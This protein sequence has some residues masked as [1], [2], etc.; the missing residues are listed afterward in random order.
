MEHERSIIDI[1]ERDRPKENETINKRVGD[2][3]PSRGDKKATT[4]GMEKSS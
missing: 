3:G 2:R 1:S 4:K